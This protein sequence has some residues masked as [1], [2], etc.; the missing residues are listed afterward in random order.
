MA[1]QKENTN[2]PWTPPPPPIPDGKYPV[3]N[4]ETKQWELKPLPP[5]EII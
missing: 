3:W 1:T 2:H 4:A 5:K